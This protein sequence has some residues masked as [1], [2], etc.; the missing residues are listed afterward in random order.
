MWLE[1]EHED[2]DVRASGLSEPGVWTEAVAEIPGR[3][4]CKCSSKPRSGDFRV[5]VDR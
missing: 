1:V 3:T 5:W 4:R 2:V